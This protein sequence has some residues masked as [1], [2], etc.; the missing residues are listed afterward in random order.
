MVDIIAALRAK[1]V[2]F[3]IKVFH[4]SAGSHYTAWEVTMQEP[5][6]MAKFM[7]D[8]FPETIEEQDLILF[9]PIMF[10]S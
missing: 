2:A 5:E 10:V 1:F 6:H 8:D 7:D 9:H 4:I 3:L